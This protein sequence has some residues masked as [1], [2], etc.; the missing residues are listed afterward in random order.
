MNDKKVRDFSDFQLSNEH[1]VTVSK[2]LL[3]IWRGLGWG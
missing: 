2:Y 3:D 1:F